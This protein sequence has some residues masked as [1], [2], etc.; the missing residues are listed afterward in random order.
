MINYTRKMPKVFV[1]ASD[2]ASFIGQNKWDYVTPFERLWKKCEPEEYTRLVESLKNRLECTQSVLKLQ[3]ETLSRDLETGR[4]TDAEYQKK[5]KTISVETDTL[6]RVN[7]TTKTQKELLESVVGRDLVVEIEND[8][9]ISTT[10]KRKRIDAA[11][12]LADVSETRKWSLQKEAESFVNKSHG[13]LRES[14]AIEMFCSQTG[15]EL[16][17]SQKFF[18]KQIHVPWESKYGWYIGGKLDGLHEDYLVEVKNRTARFFKGLRDYE[19]TQIHTYMYLTDKPAAKL[20]EKCRD[21]IRI[22]HVECD[23]KYTESIIA[24]LVSFLH[25]FEH[26]FL[27]SPELKA[28]FVESSADTKRGIIGKLFFDCSASPVESVECLI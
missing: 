9:S 5:L 17:T 2:V 8:A 4:I 24:R 25:T 7:D 23:A 12:G 15:V 1:F 14:G 27:S 11:I 21:A 28:Q 13:T 26:T 3:A 20:V 6:E 10:E 19:K 16:D 18:M 22:S